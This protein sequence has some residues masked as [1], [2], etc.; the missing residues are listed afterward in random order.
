MTDIDILQSQL[1][2]LEPIDLRSEF[3][4]RNDFDFIVEGSTDD[5]KPFAHE[6]QRE[7]LNILTS[8]ITKYNAKGKKI[9]NTSLLTEFLFGGAANGAKTWTGCVW[10]LFMC[11]C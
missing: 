3:F 8:G 6:K 9:K 5:G 4:T 10:L 7:A 2:S 11:I 1:E